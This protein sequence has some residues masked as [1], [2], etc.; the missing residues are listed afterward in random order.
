MDA[1]YE[2]VQVKCYSGYKANEQPIAEMTI[3]RT[4]KGA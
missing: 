2:K 4:S 3:N 1:K